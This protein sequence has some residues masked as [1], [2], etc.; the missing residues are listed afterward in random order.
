[1][2]NS[3]KLSPIIRDIITS[4]VT[5]TAFGGNIPHGGVTR[6]LKQTG[7]APKEGSYTQQGS[8]RIY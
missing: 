3:Y 8:Y 6:F 2:I 5:I 1:M 7:S 4:E